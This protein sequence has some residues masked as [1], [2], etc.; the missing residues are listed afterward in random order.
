VDPKIIIRIIA[1]VLLAGSAFACAVEV[2]RLGG[3]ADPSTTTQ[4]DNSDPLTDELARCN[5][6]GAKATNDAAC[7][8]AWA[9]NRK[10]FFGTGRAQQGPPSDLFPALPNISAQKT[11]HKTELDRVPSAPRPNADSAS[12]ADPEG[13]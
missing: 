1:I 7:Q 11:P 2:G 13:H 8:A 6:L 3:D 4:T 12:N 5:A 10:H 9:K